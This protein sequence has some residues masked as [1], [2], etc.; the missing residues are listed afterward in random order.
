MLSI[1]NDVCIALVIYNN[2]YITFVGLSEYSIGDTDGISDG[3]R[4]GDIDGSV[5]GGRDGSLVIGWALEEKE[6]I[7]VLGI[8]VGA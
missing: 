5:D 4:E 3:D 2:I 8:L 1:S 7:S 6:G